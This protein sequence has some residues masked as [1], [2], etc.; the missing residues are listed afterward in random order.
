MEDEGERSTADRKKIDEKP[1]VDHKL[2]DGEGKGRLPDEDKKDV[3]N[4]Q[5]VVDT[6]TQ[7]MECGN[8]QIRSELLRSS[9]RVENSEVDEELKRGNDSSASGEQGR[10]SELPT[11]GSGASVDSKSDDASNQRV[12]VSSPAGDL[13]EL[14]GS[15]L[16][17]PGADGDDPLVRSSD[18]VVLPSQFE[19]ITECDSAVLVR[20][21]TFD[22]ESGAVDAAA[23]RTPSDRTS[24]D[25]AGSPTVESSQPVN[26][27]VRAAS[28]SG[29]VVAE[30]VAATGGSTALG[31]HPALLSANV[32]DEGHR[33]IH[34]RMEAGEFGS[35]YRL[36]PAVLQMMQNKYEKAE[37]DSALRLDPGHHPVQVRMETGG[38]FGSVYRVDAAALQKMRMEFEKAGTDSASSLDKSA[39]SPG[40]VVETSTSSRL[41]GTGVSKF[42]EK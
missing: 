37:E 21:T 40:D 30:T 23:S 9:D 42:P 6:L 32:G 33:P 14:H 18:D 4:E 27:G 2:Q 24:V 28:A 8:L 38:E 3:E 11:A 22:V 35:V 5:V 20:S 12:D 10:E 25:G 15:S 41:D 13:G 36:D 29:T 19:L 17:K 34:V 26:P 31:V 7:L 1:E 39:S 16:S